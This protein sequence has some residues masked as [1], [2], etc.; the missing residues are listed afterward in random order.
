T[1]KTAIIAK[2]NEAMALMPF[3]INLTVEERKRQ[4]GIGN[5]N[6]SYVQKCLEGAI[7]FPS[8]MK[9]SFSTPEF[10]KDVNLFNALLGIQVACQALFEKVDD[11]MKAAGI[12]SMGSSSE[13]YSTLKTSAK[14]NANVKSIVDE[15]GERFA[16][17]R[18]PKTPKQG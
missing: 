9:V 6:L 18:K 2:I 7:A 17:Q 4:K 5:K 1:E 14:S 15:I 3:L 8:E 16:A 13:V 11:T 12:D 10:Q